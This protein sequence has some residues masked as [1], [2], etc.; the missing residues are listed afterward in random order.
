MSSHES[1][2]K[3]FRFCLVG[4]L[5]TLL[6]LSVLW[7]FTYRFG[8]HYLLSVI[9]AFFTINLV[10]FLIN[11]RYT[12]K[13]QTAAGQQLAKYYLVMAVSLTVNLLL[14]NLLVDQLQINI[15][16]ASLCIT[17]M[18]ITMN[19]LSHLNWTFAKK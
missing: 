3:L 8:L 6:N 5:C 1:I 2:A 15:L 13:S 11:S 10:G 19:F 18:F 16:T 14:M 7:L 17:L 9:I 4:L 12:F